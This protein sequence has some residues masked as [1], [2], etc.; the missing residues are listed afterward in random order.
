MIEYTYTIHHPIGERD[1]SRRVLVRFKHPVDIMARTQAVVQVANELDFPPSEMTIAWPS[2]T[3]LSIML[4]VE[5]ALHFIR[6]AVLELGSIPEAEG[7]SERL[8][9]NILFSDVYYSVID[10]CYF[11]S[12][13]YLNGGLH[14]LRRV[15]KEGGV[16]EL[17]ACNTFESCERPILGQLLTSILW[18]AL[19]EGFDV[20]FDSRGYVEW[21][22][23]ER[24]ERI[25]FPRVILQCHKEV[26]N[27][28][29]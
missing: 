2:N 25:N 14:Q 12:K 5:D 13:D 10:Q 4:D 9:W 22:D 27:G 18:E 16:A 21:D 26:K 17:G 23:L 7:D 1:I 20:S 8:C 28:N 3:L 29:V 6:H 11:E 19:K 24:S 15:M